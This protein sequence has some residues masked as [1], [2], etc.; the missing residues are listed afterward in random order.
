[1]VCEYNQGMKQTLYEGRAFGINLA[2]ALL[3]LSYCI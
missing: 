1:M 3:L 2:R